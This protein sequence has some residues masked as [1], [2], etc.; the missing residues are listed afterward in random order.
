MQWHAYNLLS[1]LRA[2]AGARALPLTSP[3]RPLAPRLNSIPQMTTANRGA[4]PAF[5]ELT[6]K[7][8][9]PRAPRHLLVRERLKVGS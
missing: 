1:I 2:A 4:Q 3:A 6:L 5:S 9:P 8:T 7:T